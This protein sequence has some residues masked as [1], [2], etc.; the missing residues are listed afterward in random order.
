LEANGKA[1]AVAGEAE[2][3]V[4]RTISLYVADTVNA[5]LQKFVKK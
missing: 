1:V 4:K 2:N 5:T 3:S